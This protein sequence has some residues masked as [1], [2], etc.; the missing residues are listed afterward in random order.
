MSCFYAI[1]FNL[2]SLHCR[3]FNGAW[4]LPI[5]MWGG[6]ARLKKSLWGISRWHEKLVHCLLQR[7]G[8]WYSKSLNTHTL[9]KSEWS[10]RS[11][12]ALEELDDEFVIFT[13]YLLCVGGERDRFLLSRDITFLQ[14]YHDAH[15]ILRSISPFGARDT[16]K[17]DERTRSSSIVWRRMKMT[18]KSGEKVHVEERESE[19]EYL[20][21][22]NLISFSL[23]LYGSL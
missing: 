20:V 22:F 18:M 21:I 2:S 13:G 14:L 11:G 1:E 3:L 19:W 23:L 7:D 8:K 17:Q 6:G 15:W 10:V 9:E 4:T 5:V 12:G 16:M